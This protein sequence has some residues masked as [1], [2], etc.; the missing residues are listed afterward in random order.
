VAGFNQ[1][2]DDS[3]ATKTWRYG[4]GI[5]H[6]F[7]RPLHIGAEFSKRDLDVPIRD[8]TTS[9][10][11]E[12]NRDEYFGRAYLFWTPLEYLALSGEYQ[13]EKFDRNPD[14][15]GEEAIVDL[16]THR[17]PLGVRFFHPVGFIAKCKGTYVNQDGD[18]GNSR[19]GVESDDDQF[20]VFDAS[21]GYRLPQRFGLIEL[22]VKNMF[23]ENFKFQDTDPAN[24]TIL[25]DRMFLGRMTLSF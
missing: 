10:V 7:C 2:F 4:V 6:S 17:V 20:W 25:P 12:T 8:L 1:F 11:R 21:I 18:F 16:K 23:D 19:V 14:A 15:P 5:D 3:E 24:P 22:E 9:K 13:F